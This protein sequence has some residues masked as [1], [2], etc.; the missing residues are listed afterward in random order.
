MSGFGYF[1]D[2]RNGDRQY[3]ASSFEEWL[4]KFFTTGVFNGELFVTSTGGMG[5]SV[6]SGYCNVNGKVM[7]FGQNTYTLDAAYSAADRVDTVVIE[8]NDPERT[9]SMKVV[10]GNTDGQ[11]TPPVRE[12]GIYQLVI[13]QISIGRG[14]SAIDQT[15]ITDTRANDSLCGY[16]VSTVEHINIEQ[17]LEQVK[18][19]F[20]LWFEHVQDMLD[21][22]QAA[23]LQHEID[24]LNAY[25]DGKSTWHEITLSASGW[26]N[27]EYSL[28][29][30]YSSDVYDITAVLPTNHTTSTQL[31][32]WGNARCGG[33]QPTNVI[34][35]RGTVPSIDIIVG[36]CVRKQ[37]PIV[38][39]NET[40]IYVDENGIVNFGIM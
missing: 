26:N 16:V 33:Y 1:W 15:N 22:N 34:V 17:A 23:H 36:V 5:I 18:T 25:K 29:S 30:L 8:R 39:F 19:E 37:A 24:S 12:G 27:G 38:D 21:D 35:A 9:I 10:K 6:S 7:I 32:A 2:S 13:A 20:E 14:I 11:P 40:N 3:N 31:V 4:R 28:E